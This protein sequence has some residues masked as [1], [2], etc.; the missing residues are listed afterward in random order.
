VPARARPGR[1]NLKSA[2]VSR[3]SGIFE[4]TDVAAPGGGRAPREVAQIFN[5]LDRRVA[6]GG[7]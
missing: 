6:F 2:Q 3:I 5:L 1:S 7:P 4:M